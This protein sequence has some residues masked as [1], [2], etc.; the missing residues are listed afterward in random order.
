MKE[1]LRKEAETHD[2]L[3]RTHVK[4]RVLSAINP[5]EFLITACMLFLFFYV[6]PC[7]VVLAFNFIKVVVINK[8][9]I[10]AFDWKVYSVDQVN[11]FYLY[12]KGWLDVVRDKIRS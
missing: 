5:F 1:E 3:Q 12:L 4:P 6:L 10:D 11:G 7:G 9:P 8:I 2:D